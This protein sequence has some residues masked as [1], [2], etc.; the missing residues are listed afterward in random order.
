MKT[1]AFFDTK[2]YDRENFDRWNTQYQIRYLPEKLSEQMVVLQ[3]AVDCVF[4][5]CG[6][7]VVVDYKTDRAKEAPEL[8]RRYEAQLGLYCE[9]VSQCLGLPVKECLLYSFHLNR[10]ISSAEVG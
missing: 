2:P 5:E 6:E 1:I 4:E 8:W 9:A 7:L 10:Q 3:G